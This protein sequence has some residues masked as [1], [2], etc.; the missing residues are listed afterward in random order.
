MMLYELDE[1]E[2]AVFDGKV[3]PPTATTLKL[4]RR[5]EQLPP[6]WLT[7][8]ETIPSGAPEPS[9][10]D[11][12]GRDTWMLSPEGFPRCPDCATMLQFAG[13]ALPEEG[14]WSKWLPWQGAKR[15]R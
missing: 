8:P 3:P 6:W 2:R 10:C 14:D 11:G 5:G 1:I 15:V 4:R 12:C 13:Q 7:R 9:A